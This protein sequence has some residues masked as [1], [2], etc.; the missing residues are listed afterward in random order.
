[1]RLQD[2]ESPLDVL[3]ASLSQLPATGHPE[4]EDLAKV[5]S[6]F[7]KLSATMHL[8]SICLTRLEYEASKGLAY[9]G[10]N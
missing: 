1:V 2:I 6:A 5:N 9:P 3:R 4:V 8:L 7:S 10:R